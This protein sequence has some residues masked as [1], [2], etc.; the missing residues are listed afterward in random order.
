M[1]NE[2]REI[3]STRQLAELFGVSTQT[4]DRWRKRGALKAIVVGLGHPRFT[5]AAVDE[6]IAA[7]ESK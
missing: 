2:S 3:F 4:V 5:R 1:L 7:H 6:F